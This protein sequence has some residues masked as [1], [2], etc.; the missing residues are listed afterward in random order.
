MAMRHWQANA[1]QH[2]LQSY[3]KQTLTHVLTA[4]RIIAQV[5]HA[6]IYTVTLTLLLI[7][8]SEMKLLLHTTSALALQG[9]LLTVL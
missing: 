5:R 8:S 7:I 4:W 1:A 3:Q 6:M 2:H 9:I